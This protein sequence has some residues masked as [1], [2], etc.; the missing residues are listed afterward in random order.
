MERSGIH[1]KSL[2]DVRSST[3]T[4]SEEDL[5]EEPDLQEDLHLLAAAAVRERR[6][7]THQSSYLHFSFLMFSIFK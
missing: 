6:A 4:S 2:A 5:L 3:C 7:D 1:G